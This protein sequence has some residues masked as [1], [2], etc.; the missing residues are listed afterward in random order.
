VL[1][2]INPD[3]TLYPP[4]EKVA[5]LKPLKREKKIKRVDI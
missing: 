2:N 1:V 4:S 5:L 3:C